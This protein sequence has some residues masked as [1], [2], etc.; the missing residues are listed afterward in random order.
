MDEETREDCWGFIVV[1]VCTNWY[2]STV[3]ASLTSC[4]HLYSS[5]LDQNTT[6]VAWRSSST[7]NSQLPLHVS[8]VYSAPRCH[9]DHRDGITHA[10]CCEHHSPSVT[11]HLLCHPLWLCFL[12]LLSC[13]NSPISESFGMKGLLVWHMAKAHSWPQSKATDSGT[14]HLDKVLFIKSTEVDWRHLPWSYQG[15]FSLVFLN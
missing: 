9:A 15:A 11:H 12:H 3:W 2:I 4:R 6:I 13:H 7:N 1:I 5:E 14:G 8:L 10:G